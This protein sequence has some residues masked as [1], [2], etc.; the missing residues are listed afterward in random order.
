[1]RYLLFATINGIGPILCSRGY[2]R[3]DH[4][5]PFGFETKAKAEKR[6]RELRKQFPGNRYEVEPVEDN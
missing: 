5:D 4:L 1:M 2:P 6:A 3:K